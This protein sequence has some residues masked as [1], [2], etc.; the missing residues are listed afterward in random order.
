[1]QT[2]P[3]FE[4][5][6]AQGLAASQSS[7]AAAALELFAQAS[8]LVPASGLPHFL[9]GSEHAAAGDIEAAEA[10]FARAVLLAP[11]FVLARYQLG[12]LQFTSRRAMVALLTWQPLFALPA[13]EPMGHFVRGFEALARDGFADALAHYREGLACHDL[14]EA[15]AADIRRVIQALEQLS[16]HDSA[17]VLLSAY[18]RATH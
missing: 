14:N 7:Q 11:D 2:E 3:H 1:M 5:L 16:P 4:Q 13:G 9:I 17:H 8:A 15:M 6:I 10:A 12:L 18:T